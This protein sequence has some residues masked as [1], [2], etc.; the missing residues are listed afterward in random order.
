[1]TAAQGACAAGCL[2][3]WASNERVAT[4]VP[5]ELQVR[6]LLGYPVSLSTLLS[7][8]GPSPE[9]HRLPGPA[10]VP[11]P[12][13][14]LR[15]LLQSQP[16]LPGKSGACDCSCACPLR[17]SAYG[18]GYVT[19]NKHF[20]TRLA[21]QWRKLCVASSALTHTLREPVAPAQPVTGLAFKT[22]RL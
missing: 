6:N 2:P 7:D 15:G 5:N 16:K 8:P 4:T 10:H 13:P 12:E 19:P 3:E 14:K 11:F 9:L 21:E 22:I 17:K 1:M 20:M 18:P